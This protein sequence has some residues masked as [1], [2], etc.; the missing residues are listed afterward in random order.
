MKLTNKIW[1]SDV[2][3]VIDAAVK[4]QYIA[5]RMTTV[6]VHTFIDPTT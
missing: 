4:G 1:F 2:V 3:R 5:G 6:M